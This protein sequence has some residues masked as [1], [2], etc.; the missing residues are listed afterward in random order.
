MRK[1]DARGAAF[2]F[3][4]NLQKTTLTSGSNPNFPDVSPSFAVSAAIRKSHAS[5][6]VSPPATAGPLIIATT[7]LSIR[8]NA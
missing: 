2:T 8:C 5:A 3:P 6:K 1:F 4:C 7:G